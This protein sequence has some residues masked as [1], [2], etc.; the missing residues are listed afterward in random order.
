MK[1]VFFKNAIETELRYLI[2][3]NPS[4]WYRDEID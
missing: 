4:R 1:D 3:T 2:S